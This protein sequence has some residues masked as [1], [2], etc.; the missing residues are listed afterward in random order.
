MGREEE[1]EKWWESDV[2]L[3][4]GNPVKELHWVDG[5]TWVVPPSPD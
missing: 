2:P 1:K 5:G 4:A 3:P